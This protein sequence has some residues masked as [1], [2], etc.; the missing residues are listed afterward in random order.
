MAKNFTPPTKLKKPKAIEDV[1][2]VE[3]KTDGTTETSGYPLEEFQ[4]PE[5]KETVS[6]KTITVESTDIKDDKK[7]STKI[8]FDDPE[9]LNNL[10]NKKTKESTS[11]TEEAASKK[12]DQFKGITDPEIIRKQIN[13]QEAQ[14]QLK[15]D[16][17]EIISDLGV[18]TLD[19][20]MTTILRVIAKDNTDTPYGITEAKKTK[21]KYLGALLLIKYKQKFSIELLFIITLFSAYFPAGKS[22]FNRRVALA[23]I[24]KLEDKSDKS[25]E[26]HTELGNLKQSLKRN[27]GAQPK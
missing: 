4:T 9:F 1:A 26:E 18:E 11:T 3:T 15:V 8:N 17:F 21:L 20:V 16:D 12:D 23:R 6:K 27:Q 5:E 10:V 25:K 7:Q 14:S 2:F 13:D 19:T 22:A 24:E